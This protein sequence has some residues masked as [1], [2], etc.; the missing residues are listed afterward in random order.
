MFVAF[1]ITMAAVA[2]NVVKGV[3]TDS[4]GEAVIGANVV[5]KGTTNGSI[6]DGKGEFSLNN[7]SGKDI[8]VVSFI[9]YKSQEIPIKNRVNIK[10]ILV[11]DTE[12]L[13][14][15]VVVG[16]GVQKKGLLTAA[17]STVNSEEVQN[18]THVS[19][20]QRL[21]GKVAGLQIR[22]N[23]SAPGNFD[24]SINIRGFGTPLFI[25]DGTTRVSAS[26]FQRINP[27]DIESISVLKDGAAAIYGM[28]AG[29]GVIL[30]T[31]KRGSQGKTK[32]Q[33]TG[34]FS[35]SSPTEMP[36]MM[37][38]FQWVEMRNDASVNV[39]LEPVYTPETVDNWR[40][41]IPGY[42]ST[43]WYDETMKNS[44]LSQQHTISAQGGNEKI[45]YFVS[46]GYMADPGL[47][48]TNDMKYEQYSFRS[49]L[50]AQLTNRLKAEIDVDG[51]YNTNKNTV[52]SFQEIMRGTVSEL[53]IHTPYANN[54]PDYPAYVYDGQAV[55]PVVVS[56]ADISGYSKGTG[57]S[58][59]VTA[60][61]MYDIPYV[62][63]L[64][65]KG[66]AHYEHGNS[67]AKSLM[68]SFEWFTYN[69]EEDTYIPQKYYD[70]SRLSTG[71]SNANGITLQAYLLYKNTFYKKHNV[72][73][74]GVYEERKSW[75]QTGGAARYF[76]FLSNDQ[77]DFGDMEN[78]SN[79]GMENETG[80][81]S[82]LGRA[83]YD[84]AGKYMMEF[85]ARYDG[86][87]RYHP[88][89]RWGFFPV[90]QVG[91]RISEE[92]FLKK[93]SS[94]LSNLKLRGSYGVVGEDAGSPFQYVG[95][96]TLGG[97]GY[98]FSNGSYTMGASSPA[99]TNPDLTW[100]TS[101]IANVGVDVGLLGGGLN[102][103][104]D[105][106][107]RNR[108]GLL[109]KRNVSL[110]NTFGATLPQENLNKDR[111]RG[112]DFAIGYA[113][114][115]TKDLS[116][117]LNA[118]FNFART[119]TVYSEHG[120]YG[121]SMERWRSCMDGRW[122]D[123]VWMYD[124]VGQF[125][126]EEDIL[127]APIQD[128]S[129]GN[130]KELPGDFQ[131]RDV[132]GDGVIDGN[133]VIPLAW[134]GSPKMHYGF[135]IGAKYKDFDFNMLL[136]GSAKYSVRFTY[137]YGEM[138]S[139]DG[140]M[141]EYFY[142]R[143]HLSDPFN[144][145]SEWVAGKWPAARRKSDVGAMYNE[146]SIWRHDAS[147]LR[148]KSVELGYSVPEKFLLPVGIQGLRVYASAYNLFTFCDKFVKPFD[149]EKIEGAY[150][151][152]WVY[153]LNKSFNFGVNLTF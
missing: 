105:I 66:V 22:Q 70:P 4:N 102:L 80:F 136:Q 74:T 142:D 101:R 115:L 26:E 15:V 84:Y 47:T 49:N 25:I 38:A 46:F 31:T 100:L 11:D 98:E 12:L 58:M 48:K 20:A 54:N 144:P 108:K 27:E 141:P 73:F 146:S 32:F 77:V 3:V 127:Y 138:F 50:T 93:Y 76:K 7:V 6:T 130:S 9:G 145:D 113:T 117:N 109:A 149:P 33:Y 45:N 64:Q 90:V 119:M 87:Y 21:E 61:L 111:V 118:N 92:E 82:F 88:D 131:Y 59:K 37:N 13:E 72:S 43:D 125:Q 148:I 139:L 151:A 152:G 97:S 10:I 83:T 41:G 52:T 8:L 5:V 42:E 57:K 140:N 134:G 40:K 126:S 129:L 63:G 94:F 78:M 62:K 133:D 121:N 28:N 147:Y 99:L 44:V 106:Y 19:L 56:N 14:E 2:Q 89:S 103:T 135:T 36:E 123:I 68:K 23:S 143:W 150:N 107:Q 85:A 120:S 17:V 114:Q 153:P 1:F 124:Y 51:L 67:Y 69:A 39:G 53:P 79:S 112:F 35:I 71:W 91:W 132:N 60:S 18:T 104:F 81:M 110:P 116:I 137:N 55:N 29:S 65:L 122:Q 128:G 75:S 96:F 34:T 86:S 30:V 24:S 16:Y 95:G